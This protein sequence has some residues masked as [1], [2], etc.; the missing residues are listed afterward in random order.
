MSSKNSPSCYKLPVILS[1][2]GQGGKQNSGVLR[3]TPHRQGQVWHFYWIF[4]AKEAQATQIH[5]TSMNVPAAW[6]VNLW[7]PLVSD[8]R[9]CLLN[10]PNLLHFIQESEG[11]LQRHTEPKPLC[12][13]PDNYPSQNN[14]SQARKLHVL[15]TTTLLNRINSKQILE[16]EIC[17]FFSRVL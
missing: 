9:T 7:H 14:S 2:L 15:W 16:D 12:T 8:D 11:K 3:D 10:P 1:L 6:K 5:L 4:T 17:D 13:I